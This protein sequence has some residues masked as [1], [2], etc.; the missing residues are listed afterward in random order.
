[1]DVHLDRGVRSL[2]PFFRLTVEETWMRLSIL[3]SFGVCVSRECGETGVSVLSVYSDLRSAVVLANLLLAR[4]S[5]R[6]GE[7]CGLG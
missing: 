2:C 5:T 3:V 7:A 4:I 6:E 1:V